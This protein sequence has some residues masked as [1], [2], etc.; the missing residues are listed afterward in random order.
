MRQAF[1]TAVGGDPVKDI[2]QTRARLL[3]AAGPIFAERGFQAAN[4]RAICRQAGVNLGAINY[5]FRSKEQ[6]YVETI[7]HA[8]QRVL[9]EEEMAAYDVDLLT[10]HITRFSLAAIRGLYPRKKESRS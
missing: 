2:E 8:L 10:D 7:R 9:G 4:V 5:H 1:E 6:F 3:E